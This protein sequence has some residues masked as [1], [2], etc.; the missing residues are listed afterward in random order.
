M[1]TSFSKGSSTSTG[2]LSYLDYTYSLSENREH[3]M[4]IRMHQFIV[5]HAGGTT[6]AGISCQAVRAGQIGGIGERKGQG[7]RSRFTV[8]QLCM[9]H[10]SFRYGL[11]QALF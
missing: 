2:A 5:F 8:K 10:T 1:E 4:K 7:T 9:G 11:Y 3:K 6:S